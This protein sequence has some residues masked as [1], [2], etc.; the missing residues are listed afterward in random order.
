MENNLISPLVLLLSGD[1]VLSVESENGPIGDPDPLE[2]MLMEHPSR[3]VY[4]RCEEEEEE[5]EPL[6]ANE[7]ICRL[8]RFKG[9]NH[10]TSGV[11]V[12]PAHLNSS[13]VM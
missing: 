10:S 3:S 12:I 6:G 4:Q 5:E 9:K 13:V 7:D 2:Q 1:P 11:T 8:V